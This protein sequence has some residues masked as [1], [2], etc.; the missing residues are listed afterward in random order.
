MDCKTA[1]TLMEFARPTAPDLDDADRKALAA[2]LAVCSD[3]DA[4]TRAERQADEHLGQAVRDVPVP[5]GLRERLLER[6]N[7][8]RDAWFRKVL[9]RGARWLAAA[10]A[11][12]LVVYGGILWMAAQKPRPEAEDLA[13]I[14]LRQVISPADRP[15]VEEWFGERG[16]K[17]V[18]PDDFDYAYLTSYN[19]A[20]FDLPAD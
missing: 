8:E 1:R 7:D 19:L 2:H 11:V 3:C 4:L 16:L 20:E 9:A 6:L 17:V 14:A 5:Q 18:A 12:A 15:G 13:N 10:A